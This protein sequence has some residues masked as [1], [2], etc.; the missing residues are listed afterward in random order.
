MYQGR[1]PQLA[2]LWMVSGL[3]L[4]TPA[5]VLAQL[6]VPGPIRLEAP[7]EAQRQVNGLAPAVEEDE[8]ISVGDVRQQAASAASVVSFGP[9]WDVTLAAAGS[10]VT[11]G[12][13]ISFVAPEAND[14]GLLLNVNGSGALP[15][16]GWRGAPLDSA[17]ILAGTPVR[18]VR[19][20]DHY[21]VL[22]KIRSV[23]PPGYT[24]FSA[25]SCIEEL[26]R[27]PMTFF[28]AANECLLQGGR[29]CTFAEWT[30]ACSLIPGFMDVVSQAEWIDHA[31]NSTNYA[32]VI[33]FGENGYSGAGS[34]CDF[35][36]LRLPTNNAPFRCCIER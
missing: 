21:L 23:C 18:V 35:G 17:A 13:V 7:S 10:V 11:E 29:L 6:T 33:G 19:L 31:A 4:G 2:V 36:G 26:P 25:A 14:P 34:G 20:T 1:Y 9:T 22:D 30:S 28:Q 32:K 27:A 3:L 5:C 8:A 16:Q 12:M 15:I 24:T